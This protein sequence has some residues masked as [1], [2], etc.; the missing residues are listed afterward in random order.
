VQN[1]SCAAESAKP[2]GAES[3]VLGGRLR[4]LAAIA[5]VIAAI[6]RARSVAAGG[7]GAMDAPSPANSLRTSRA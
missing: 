5:S 6:A 7:G 3:Y 1:E 2:P 4:D